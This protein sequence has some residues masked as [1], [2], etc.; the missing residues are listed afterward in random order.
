MALAASVQMSALEA[1]EWLLDRAGLQVVST[2]EG[3]AGT[4]VIFKALMKW[5][6]ETSDGP[7][8][9]EVTGQRGWTET[10][11]VM[12]GQTAAQVS[13]VAKALRVLSSFLTVGLTQI[14]DLAA[15]QAEH[16]RHSFPYT[17]FIQL[18]MSDNLDDRASFFLKNSA[19]ILNVG[20]VEYIDTAQ[21]QHVFESAMWKPLQG[22]LRRA[23][24]E[25]GSVGRE[26]SSCM[27]AVKECRKTYQVVNMYGNLMSKLRDIGFERLQRQTEDRVAEG[28]SVEDVMAVDDQEIGGE[29][30]WNNMGMRW[31][32]MVPTMSV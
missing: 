23:R 3:W 30:Q 31:R 26:A 32:E 8:R 27:D 9:K 21:R 13:V 12:A 15:I 29:E 5:E 2:G 1:M 14:R 18:M 6:S 25:G 16:A 7:E 10:S 20:A 22:Y 4:L 11:S 19:R 24:D 28:A 17:H